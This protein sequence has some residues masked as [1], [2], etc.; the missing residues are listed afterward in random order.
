[1]VGTGNVDDT[2]VVPAPPNDS[3]L[4]V[5]G[6]NVGVDM[7]D[8]A[9]V[10][11]TLAGGP[12]GRGNGDIDGAAAEFEPIESIPDIFR[13]RQMCVAVWDCLTERH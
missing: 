3:G 12:G 2:G 7:S 4:A 1:V 11:E 9:G 13:L 5:P 10:G 6:M 8:G